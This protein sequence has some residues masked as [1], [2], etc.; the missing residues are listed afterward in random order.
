MAN[1]KAQ[2]KK[3]E[4]RTAKENIKIGEKKVVDGVPKIVIKQGRKEDYLSLDE[5]AKFLYAP[6]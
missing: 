1:K 3:N 6:E 5:I 4:I 2:T